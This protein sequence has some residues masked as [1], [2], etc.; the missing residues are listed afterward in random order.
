MSMFCYQCE[1]AAGGTGCTRVGVCG[2]DPQVAALQDLLIH[3]LKG[4]AVYG[5]RGRQLGVKD[6]GVDRFVM[7]GLF[8]TVTNV[9]FD[10]ERLRGL[11]QECVHHRENLKDKFLEA[12]RQHEGKEFTETLPKETAFEPAESLEDM[13]AQGQKVGIMSDP[14]MDED[15]RSL[16]ELFTYGLK[17]MAAYA[18]HA[19]ILGKEKEEVTAFF[20]KA[21]MP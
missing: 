18:D 17:G 7:E 11:I 12:Y 8:S 6:E 20:Y 13:V 1:Q 3:A 15:I 16:R 2:K 9:D 21:F 14:D 4:L 5:Y 10:P 19:L